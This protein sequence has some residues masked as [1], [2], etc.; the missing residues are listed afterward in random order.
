MRAGAREFP[1]IELS[2]DGA[3]SFGCGG[4][5]FFAAFTR[6][7][8]RRK[9]LRP[10]AER[11]AVLMVV[12][13]RRAA[14]DRYTGYLYVLVHPERDDRLRLFGVRASGILV[15]AG[16]VDLAD[17]EARIRVSAVPSPHQVPVTVEATYDHEARRISFVT[18]VIDSDFAPG[19]KGSQ[20]P[21][22]GLSAG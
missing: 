11:P 9:T 7:V 15:V 13:R 12:M 20:R 3:L 5:D 22:P 10:L 21:S 17:R 6:D 18:A 2:A 8:H 4:D 14:L 16:E 19:T 1:A